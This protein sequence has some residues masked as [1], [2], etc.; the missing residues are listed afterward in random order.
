MK[1]RSF[2]ITWLQIVLAMLL[3][4]SLVLVF[5]GSVAGCLLAGFRVHSNFR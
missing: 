3:G 2:W 4:Y 1:D 5:A